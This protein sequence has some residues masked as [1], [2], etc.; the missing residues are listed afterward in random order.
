MK[1]LVLIA[2]QASV[3]LIVFGFGLNAD[4]G[5]LRGLFRRPRLLVR[6]TVAMFVIMPVLAVTLVRVFE[7]PQTVRIALVALAISPIPPLFP[8][9]ES[10]AGG[11]TAD[12]VALMVVLSSLS[13]VTI[14]ASLEVLNAVFGLSLG[15]APATVAGIVLRTVLGPVAAGMTVRRLMPA[16]AAR[17]EK[18]VMRVGG[19]LIAV[20]VVVLLAA[21]APAVWALVGDGT[22]VAMVVFTAAGLLVGHLL[23]APNR[24]HSVVLALSTACRHPAMALTVV[25][26]NFRDERSGGAIVLYL[27]VSTLVAVPYIAWRRRIAAAQPTPRPA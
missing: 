22:I 26:A 14:P 21:T 25:S 20:V 12:G 15:I 8:R 5:S 7:F 9:N 2:V 10:K 13:I 19:L 1:Q 4:I 6:S 16:V 3:M 17:I 18:P 11:S 24:D 27:L 23:G